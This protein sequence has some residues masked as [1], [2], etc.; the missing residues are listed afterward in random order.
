MNRIRGRLTFPSGRRAKPSLI[1]LS[2]VRDAWDSG[3]ADA[4][5]LT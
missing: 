5:R 1:R 2:V 4:C 3:E